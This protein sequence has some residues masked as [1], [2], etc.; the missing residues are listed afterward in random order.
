MSFL[1]VMVSCILE[2]C[3]CIIECCF[4]VCTRELAGSFFMSKFLFISFTI[5]SIEPMSFDSVSLPILLFCLIG[6]CY[7][8]IYYRSNLLSNNS[9]E[10]ELSC[11][12]E[13]DYGKENCGEFYWNWLLFINSFSKSAYFFNSKALVGVYEYYL[14]F[15]IGERL[16]IWIFG[17]L[18]GL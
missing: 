11:I 17:C 15:A 13:A 16:F 12:Y 1:V 14:V 6:W 9:N 5:Y 18:V 3:E 8:L 4:S 2:Y 7:C 10:G